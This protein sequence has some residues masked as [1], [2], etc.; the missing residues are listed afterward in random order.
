MA[1]HRIQKCVNVRIGVFIANVSIYQGWVHQGEE[2]VSRSR[3]KIH[4]VTGYATSDPAFAVSHAAKSIDVKF[5]N[6]ESIIWASAYT[7]VISWRV[8][9]TKAQTELIKQLARVSGVIF[10]PNQA[11]NKIVLMIIWPEIGN[12]RR[13]SANLCLDSCKQEG[14][15]LNW[16]HGGAGYRVGVPKNL[17]IRLG[18]TFWQLVDAHINF[19]RSVL[20]FQP[21]CDGLTEYV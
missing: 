16:C 5:G 2:H 11:I 12:A 1:L 18:N 17:P 19:E 13:K 14:I 20:Q 10:V 15:K 3:T 4:E 21:M 6:V 7:A 8:K 9:H